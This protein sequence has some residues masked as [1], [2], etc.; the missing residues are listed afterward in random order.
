MKPGPRLVLHVDMD[1]FFASVEQRTYPFLRGRPVGVCGDPEGRTVVAAASY[2]A[3]RRGVKTAMTV[4]AARRLCPDIVLVP[5][6][7]AKYI[8]SSVRI[9]AIY[10]EYTDLVEVFS[11]DEAFLDV[12]GSAH[13][14][15]GAEAVGRAIK[16][17]VRRRLGLNCS[18]GVAPNKLV[19]K[20]ASDLS[21]P[22]GLL[23]VRPED[24]PA[25]MAA[26]PVE[27]LCGIGPRTR[28]ELAR[29]GI[30]TCAELGRYPERRLVARFGVNGAK[31]SRMGRGEDPSPVR[32]G[33]QAPDAK[34]VGHSL[35]LA[36]DTRDPAIIRRHLLQLSEQVGRRLRRDGYAGRTVSIVIRYA[37]FTTRARRHSLAGHLSDGYRV[38]AAGLRLFGELYEAG[39]FVR[40]LGISVS[41]LTRNFA[42]AELFNSP[43]T[44]AGD[45]LLRATDLVND[46]FGEFA[47]ARAG[48]IRRAPA[49][50]VIPPS[51]RPRRD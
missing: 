20:L 14:H 45:M 22:D 7:P 8:D 1:A 24:L 49:S 30:R 12:T 25:L 33:V 40:L 48:L 2:E 4:P 36:Q 27:K 21:K 38:Y 41:T 26:T 51:W 3:K 31:L 32:P 37:D 9:L 39:R 13:L 18:V 44:P 19:A 11:I 10:G 15:G 34:S 42:Q 6:D 17:E 23:V 28:E 5:G 46:R 43:E 35:T 50:R 47:V 29:L 16:A